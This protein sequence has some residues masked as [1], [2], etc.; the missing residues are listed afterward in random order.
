MSYRIVGIDVHKKMLAVVVADIAVEGEY[1]FER[2]RFDTSPDQLR[3][4]G[5]W[6]IQQQAEEVV[7]ESTAPYG[8]PVW[9]ALEPH[10]KPD[11][12]RREG[13]GPMSGTLPL[14]QAQSHRGRRGGARGIFPMPNAW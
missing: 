5:E 9:A 7:M 13:A 3:L 12:Q 2:R 11:G 6:L 10:G 4:L 14:A 1:Q 8:K